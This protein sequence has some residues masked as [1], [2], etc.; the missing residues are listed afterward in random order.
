MSKDGYKKTLR[1]LQIELVKLQRH[2][3]ANDYKILVILE[4]RDAAGKD[5]TINVSSS[6]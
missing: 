6:I 2:M 1:G 4:G 5:G 3:L